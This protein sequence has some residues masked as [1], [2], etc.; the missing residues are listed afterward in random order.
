MVCVVHGK[1]G[2]SIK[3][4]IIIRVLC[5]SGTYEEDRDVGCFANVY[6]AVGYVYYH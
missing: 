1:L 2:K 4:E 3:K 6:G 5:V